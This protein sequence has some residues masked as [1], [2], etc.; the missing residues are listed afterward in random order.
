MWLCYLFNQLPL[1]HISQDERFDSIE[2]ISDLRFSFIAFPWGDKY[3]YIASFL[4]TLKKFEWGKCLRLSDIQPPMELSELN[5]KVDAF[6]ELTKKT[7]E[8]DSK[9]RI[10]FLKHKNEECKSS[11]NVLN[12]KV[13][14]YIAVVLVYAVFFDPVLKSV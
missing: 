3:L 1:F 14:S 8:E 11:L 5:K 4:F 6:Y 9:L 13:N 7:A 2:N 12:N 10:E